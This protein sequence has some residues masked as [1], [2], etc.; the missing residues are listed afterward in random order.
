[1]THTMVED[2]A[3]LVTR[4]RQ[5]DRHAFAELVRRY[6]D[7]AYGVAAGLLGDPELGRCIGRTKALFGVAW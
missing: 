6:Q 4:V 5:G 2:T 1:M 3:Q 7:H